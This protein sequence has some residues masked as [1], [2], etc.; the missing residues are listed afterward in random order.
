[1]PASKGEG[2]EW[3][4]GRKGMGR[5]KGGRDGEG[6]EG[7]KKGGPVPDWESAKV[8]TLY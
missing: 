8:A 6:R 5:G 7:R 4:M 3:E 1:V 2:R